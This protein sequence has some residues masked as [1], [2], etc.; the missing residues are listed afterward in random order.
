MVAGG[1]DGTPARP[2]RLRRHLA[3][4]DAAT[5]FS[6]G[7]DFAKSLGRSLPAGQLADTR[8]RLADN[9]LREDE[10]NASFAAVLRA[11]GIAP[12]GTATSAADSAGKEAGEPETAQD[13]QDVRDA[14]DAEAAEDAA[15]IE[16]NL[17]LYVRSRRR[18]AVLYGLV[19]AA[20]LAACYAGLLFPARVAI[21]RLL[22]GLACTSFVAASAL[23]CLA[24][25]W[26]VH[27]CTQRRFVPFVR[28]V[29]HLFL[30]WRRRDT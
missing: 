28:W 7:A 4:L 1:P 23:M 18:E 29:S 2:S 22:A 11:W 25:C 21:V 15:V 26:R 12:A 13:A 9:L 20:G 6:L 17:A 3:G 24:A 5:G 10:L 19:M 16:R 14:Q 27:V 30:P 8:S